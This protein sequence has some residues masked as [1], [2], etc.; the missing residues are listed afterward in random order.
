MARSTILGSGGALE[1][2]PN[3][4]VRVRGVAKYGGGEPIP[5]PKALAPMY[6]ISKT[7]VPVAGPVGLYQEVR[8]FSSPAIQELLE[9]VLARLPADSRGVEITLAAD[10]VSGINAAVAL[11][12]SGMWSIA[13]AYRRSKS[14][15]A[16]G[17]S[18]S[19]RW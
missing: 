5:D 1:V 19:G 17:L 7:L 11:K 8:R 3:G 10:P 9:T 2:L 15:W 6:E 18:V 4:E 12:L 13:A 14:D 16:A